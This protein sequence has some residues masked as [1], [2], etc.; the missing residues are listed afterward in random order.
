MGYFDERKN[1]DAYIKMAEGYDGRNLIAILQKHLVPGSTVLE[2][3]MGPGIDLDLLAQTY[4]VTGS[5][6][7]N[8]FL[9]LYREEHPTADL[10]ELDALNLKTTR[11]FDCIYSN[12]VL[13][14]LR[15]EDMHRSFSRQK[16]VLHNG[17][18]LMHS[19]WF[20]SKEEALHGLHFAYY[21]E[22][23][24]LKIIGP[25]FKV[26]AMERYQ[27]MEADDSFYLLLRKQ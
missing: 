19:F 10:L 20:G 2:L 12:K 1:V 7:S 5:D 6:N 4:Q 14:H 27:E 18:L 26:V 23:E 24:L 21:T 8:V 22:E 13:H 17:G 25:G 11:K 3:G 16:A 9:E 15:K